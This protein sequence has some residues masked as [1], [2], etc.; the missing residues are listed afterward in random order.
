MSVDP[1]DPRKIFSQS[2]HRYLVSTDHQSGPDLETI[3]QVASKQFPA[4]TV[5]V[6]TGAGHALRAA[7][8]F[9]V[10]CAALD[11]TGEMLQVAREYLV[12]S[13]LENVQF[14][15][16]YADSLPLAGGTVSLLTCRIAP[17]HFPS[18]PGFLK[19]VRRVLEPDGRCIIIDS[20][21]PE[22]A[23]CDRFIN[24]VERLRDPS[25]IRSHTLRQWMEFF[26]TAELEMI[27]VQQFE[28]NHPFREWAGR[29]GLDEG[30]VMELEKI[31]KTAAPDVR[32]RFKVQLDDE[33]RVESY[34]DEKGIFVGKK[35]KG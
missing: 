2:A 7:C 16:S 11:L 27:S 24:D 20:I 14:I 28:R 10:S 5:D 8:P 22:K 4:L 34:T 9:S 30:S 17:H 6:A 23:E 33:G 3:R 25:H 32:K 18:I 15:Q 1:G 21:V 35:G 29:T 26:Q 12:K 13:G 31:F 19:E